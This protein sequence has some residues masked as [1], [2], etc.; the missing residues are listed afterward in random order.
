MD[1][2]PAKQV[3]ATFKLL[4]ANV[5]MDKIEGVS[6]EVGDPE[7]S[8]AFMYRVTPA[9]LGA[10]LLTTKTMKVKQEDGSLVDLPRF[11]AFNEDDF[12]VD[13]YTDSQQDADNYTIVVTVDFPDYPGL[14]LSRQF[15]VEIK[16]QET[17]SNPEIAYW[18]E[19]YK[20]NFRIKDKQVNLGCGEGWKWE[21]PYPLNDELEEHTVRVKT[22][23][24]GQ[25]YTF[26]YYEAPTHEFLIRPDKIG[27]E[28]TGYY[29]VEFVLEDSEL[30]EKNY[31]IFFKVNCTVVENNTSNDELLQNGEDV[32]ANVTVVVNQQD[33]STL[34]ETETT[35]RKQGELEAYMESVTFTG[36]AFIRFNQPMTIPAMWRNIT[37]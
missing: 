28:H 1:D 4:L 22:V 21:L 32:N 31:N 30:G 20:T 8:R 2:Y 3:E 33:N 11:M 16:T 37:G 7:V 17:A 5:E 23:R 6:L 15:E 29:K 34:N 19:N 35:E 10:Q 12:S 27:S 36:V 14:T 18:D 13:I 9:A 24:R 26:L 25:A